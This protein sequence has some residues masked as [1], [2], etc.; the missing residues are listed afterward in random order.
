MNIETAKQEI[1]DMNEGN[2]ETATSLKSGST[3]SDQT[4]TDSGINMD[5]SNGVLHG[6]DQYGSDQEETGEILEGKEEVKEN[7][8]EEVEIEEDDSVEMKEDD[9]VV[10]EEEEEEEAQIGIVEGGLN[11]ILKY[12][13]GN[14]NFYGLIIS[15]DQ[16]Y[17]RVGNYPQ[18]LIQCF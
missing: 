6:I 4:E 8:T 12:F 7:V 3:H 17:F 2:S 16:P 9:A 13:E 14:G 5:S 15:Y 11:F 10:E 1:N 18:L